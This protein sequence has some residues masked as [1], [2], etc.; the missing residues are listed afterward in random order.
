[1]HT[2]S[3]CECAFSTTMPICS[4]TQAEN[5]TFHKEC[6]FLGIIFIFTKLLQKPNKN[7]KCLVTWLSL[8]WNCTQCPPPTMFIPSYFICFQRFC[9]GIQSVGKRDSRNQ[10]SKSEIRIQAKE[11]ASGKGN[12]YTTAKTP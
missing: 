8:G 1:M 5:D 9:P 6:V 10:K 7:K 4:S 12:L 3:C 2:T 11:K